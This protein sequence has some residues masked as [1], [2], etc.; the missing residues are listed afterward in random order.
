M[1][2]NP[3][4]NIDHEPMKPQK[5]LFGEDILGAFALILY[6]CQPHNKGRIELIGKVASGAESEWVDSDT[7]KQLADLGDPKQRTTFLVM[8]LH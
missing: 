7:I 5:V 3:N 4:C 1:N 6:D 8:G 2:G